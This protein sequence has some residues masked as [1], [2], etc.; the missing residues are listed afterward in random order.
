MFIK[1]VWSH[2]NSGLVSYISLYFHYRLLLAMLIIELDRH[3][4]VHYGQLTLYGHLE[5]LVQKS[6][7]SRTQYVAKNH[8]SLEKVD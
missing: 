6:A 4:Q 5:T 3:H 8:F 7:P 2:T 1:F